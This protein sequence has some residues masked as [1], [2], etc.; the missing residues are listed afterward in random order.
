[1]AETPL[2]DS[3]PTEAEPVETSAESPAPE[4]L[5]SDLP[6]D[7]ESF[8]E[9]DAV[10]P[11][12]PCLNHPSVESTLFC[13]LCGKPHCDNC[14]VEFRGR[15]ICSRCKDAE[16]MTLQHQGN[17][18]TATT[19]LFLS[20]IGTALGSL[21]CL[22]YVCSLIGLVFGYQAL[23]EMRRNPDLLFAR[24]TALAALIIGWVGI[25]F[26]SLQILYGILAFVLG[27]STTR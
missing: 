2:T 8:F 20:I 24:P 22:P 3:A 13:P 12:R 25:G 18:Q 27:A 16:V 19:A 10:L 6:F 21:C 26:A 4:T 5:L 15:K 14:V 1:M 23:Q 9:S 7:T 17:F 11:T